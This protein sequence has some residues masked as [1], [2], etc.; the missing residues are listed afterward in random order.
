MSQTRFAGYLATFNVQATGGQLSYQ[1]KKG[2]TPLLDETNS[3]LSLPNVSTNDSGTY[4]VR[5]QPGEQHQRLG[6]PDQSRCRLRSSYEEAVAGTFRWS[7]CAWA[8]PAC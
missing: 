6:D 3:T 4:M 2:T 7:I 8:K 5:V 1:W